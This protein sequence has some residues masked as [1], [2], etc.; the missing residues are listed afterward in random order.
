MSMAFEAAELA[1]DPLLAYSREEISWKEAR[2][3][4]WRSCE[5]A[6]AGRLRWARLL[7]WMLFAPEICRHFG[8]V[9]LGSDWVWRRMF[10]L[11]R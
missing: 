11:T 9:L 8:N 6:F 1:L 10:S 5:T 7:Q 3:R 2:D 4:T